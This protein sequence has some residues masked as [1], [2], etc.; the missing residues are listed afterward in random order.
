VLKPELAEVLFE[1]I[2]VSLGTLRAD[3]VPSEAFRRMEKLSEC[4]TFTNFSIFTPDSFAPGSANYSIFSNHE[5]VNLSVL[6]PHK[7]RQKQQVTKNKTETPAHFQQRIYRH[8]T[9][10]NRYAGRRQRSL[11]IF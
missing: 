2:E 4:P 1:Q 3:E 5:A 10:R 7:S 6:K 9:H 8:A 11:F